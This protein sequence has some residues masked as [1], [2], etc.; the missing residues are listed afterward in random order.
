[1]N[2]RKQLRERLDVTQRDGPNAPKVTDEEILNVLRRADDEYLTTTEV[3]SELPIGEQTSNRLNDLEE[4]SRVTKRKTGQGYLWTL[5][6][7]EPKI[8][9][10]PR[11]GPVVRWSSK[12]RRW[13]QHIWQA[14][15]NI[16]IGGV[17]LI[18]LALSAGIAEIAVPF[19]TWQ[20]ALAWGYLGAI[21]AAAFMG[22]AWL[23]RLAALGA[24]KVVERLLLT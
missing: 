21:V 7:N 6:T 24:P 10:N 4:E 3:R 15:K 18:I 22:F 12:T 2:L 13:S 17:L 8:E 9:M 14:S 5:H 1:M 20:T 23:L 16:G 11:L 19:V